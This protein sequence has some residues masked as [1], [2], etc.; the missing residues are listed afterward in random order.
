MNTLAP[1]TFGT[2]LNVRAQTSQLI[3]NVAVLSGEAKAEV[4]NR[5]YTR[6]HYHYGVD[7]SAFPRNNGEDLLTVAERHDLID[8]VYAFAYAEHLYQLAYEE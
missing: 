1:T 2:V 6:L 7:L 3:T 4:L 8:K 5:I